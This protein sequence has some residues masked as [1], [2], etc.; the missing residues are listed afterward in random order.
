MDYKVCILAAGIGSR[1]GNF[2]K[3]FNKALLPLNG[4]PAICHIIEK[5]PDE[6]S[7]II[8]VGYKKET[9]VEYL[10]HNYPNRKFKFVVVS[11]EIYIVFKR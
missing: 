7:I 6:I 3:V 11:A 2:T 4:K 9:I 1:M 8:A 5:F 10:T